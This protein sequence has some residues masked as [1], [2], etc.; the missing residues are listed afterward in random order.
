MFV[1]DGVGWDM[2]SSERWM[3][4]ASTWVYC[5]CW[6]RYI[7]HGGRFWSIIGFH[8]VDFCTGIV[9]QHELLSCRP[10]LPRELRAALLLI[11]RLGFCTYLDFWTA[12]ASLLQ[13]LF[14]ARVASCNTS[15]IGD[16]SLSFT[17]PGQRFQE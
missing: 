5:R 3:F 17:R 6:M 10:L 11:Q 8:W 9:G 7:R 15:P 12:R 13:A 2:V 1:V 16:S 14:A 4:I